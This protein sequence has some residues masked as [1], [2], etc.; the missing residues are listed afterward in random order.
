[1]DAHG[2]NLAAEPP[3]QMHKLRQPY[4]RAQRHLDRRGL[5][6]RR[7]A[8]HAHLESANGRPQE[9]QISLFVLS[10]LPADFGRYYAADCYASS[11]LQ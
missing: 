6:A 4:F 1:L 5:Y 11:V 3:L 9:S 2:F 10:R 7:L 8:Y